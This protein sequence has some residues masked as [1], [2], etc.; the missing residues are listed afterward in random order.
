[1]LFNRQLSVWVL[2]SR[3][4]AARSMKQAARIKEARRGDGETRFWI[5][6][7]CCCPTLE[8]GG[9]DEPTTRAEQSFSS[10]RLLLSGEIV[11]LMF[12]FLFLLARLVKWKTD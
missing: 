2:I 11:L 8:C 7:C 3:R 4:L 12:L 5:D 6:K 9:A 10:S 1:M